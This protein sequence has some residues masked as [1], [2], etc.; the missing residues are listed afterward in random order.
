MRHTSLGLRMK[1]K[2]IYMSDKEKTVIFINYN[3]MSIVVCRSNSW[4]I[5]VWVLSVFKLVSCKNG[6]SS[7]LWGS[8]GL[9]S[10]KCSKL[11]FRYVHH[12]ICFVLYAVLPTWFIM[13]EHHGT[14]V[15]Q[16][17]KGET[18]PVP[19]QYCKDQEDLS[20]STVL[21]WHKNQLCC[22]MIVHS[23]A[24]ISYRTTSQQG[25]SCPG[26]R[27]GEVVGDFITPR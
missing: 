11:V 2:T 27:G 22:Y 24:Q 19:L 15:D 26:A 23:M 20:C 1:F 18:S 9:R 17:Q 16:H 25:G 10:S 21:Y 8:Q 14:W 4:P 7:W 13:T 5:G 6:A 3:Y 12:F